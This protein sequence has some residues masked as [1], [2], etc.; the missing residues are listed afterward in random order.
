MK[1]VF[2]VAGTPKIG[3]K[4]FIVICIKMPAV[5]FYQMKN[6]DHILMKTDLL[7]LIIG[8]C[9]FSTQ[10]HYVML[11]EKLHSMKCQF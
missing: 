10:K 6:M 5:H 3:L 1:L 8:H 2:L 11:S 9:S 7:K 4:E